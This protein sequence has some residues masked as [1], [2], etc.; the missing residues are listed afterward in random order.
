M[1]LFHF[2]WNGL[3]MKKKDDVAYIVI[4]DILSVLNIILE[5]ENPTETIM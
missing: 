2:I 3:K 4:R 1:I 5:G